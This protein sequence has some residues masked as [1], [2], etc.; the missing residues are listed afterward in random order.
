MADRISILIV[1][2]NIEFGNLVSERISFEDGFEVA[3]LA[4]DGFQAIDMIMALKPDVVILDIVMP[5]LD[6]IGVLERIAEMK[7]EHKPIFV[8]LS[9][10]GQDIFIQKSIALGAEYYVLKPFEVGLLLSRIKEIYVKNREEALSRKKVTEMPN[11]LKENTS[12]NMI[13]LE[14]EVTNLIRGIGIPPHMH[15]YQYLR[16]AIIHTVNS[17]EP[18]TSVTKVIYPTVAEKF[19]TTPQGVERSIRN[20]IGSAWI[21]GNMDT[22]DSLFGYKADHRNEKPTNS[23]FI[24]KLADKI[25]ID[26]QVSGPKK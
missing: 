6:G 16:E 22:I 10:V 2:D 24:A 19:S 9:A 4:R 13:N 11:L 3:G 21:N 7:L 5:N 12:N 18:F 8:M 17:N 25:K 15:G 14:M 23:E 26:K 1:E 20:A